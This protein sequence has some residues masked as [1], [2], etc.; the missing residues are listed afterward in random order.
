MESNDLL[1]PKSTLN[2]SALIE[3]QFGF[4]TNLLDFGRI[5]KGESATKTAVLIMKDQSKESLLELNSPSSHVAVKT[6]K[7]TKSNKGRVD[8]EVTVKPEAQLGK[9][10]EM[11]SARLTDSSHPASSLNVSGTIVGNVEVTPETIRFMVDT[12]R[13]AANQTERIVR[14]VSAQDV[15]RLR[16]L[17]VEDPQNLV[18]IEVD[19]VVSGKQYVIRARPNENA[20][21][22]EHNYSGEIKIMTDDTEQPEMRV[23]YYIILSK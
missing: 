5:R 4:E 23:G 22:L 14:V 19:T 7:P 10:N 21:I 17:S 13:T 9:L 16:L 20:L 12:S 3:I 18:A 6:I 8:V 1:N 11:I 2:V 15:P